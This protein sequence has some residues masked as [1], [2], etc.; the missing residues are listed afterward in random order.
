MKCR[1]PTCKTV[2]CHDACCST[3]TYD[4]AILL[5]RFL[6][7]PQRPKDTLTYFQL[8]GFLFG[9][10]NGPELIPP[11][12]WIPLVQRSRCAVRDRR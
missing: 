7:A 6:S 10:A 11:S 8:A 3:T 2:S 12:E 5:T 9:L 4:Q 1:G